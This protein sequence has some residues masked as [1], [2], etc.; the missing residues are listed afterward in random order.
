[1][2]SRSLSVRSR[3]SIGTSSPSTRA[4]A[5]DAT[6][7]CMSLPPS[8]ITRASSPSKSI[9]RHLAYRRP[10]WAPLPLNGGA[11]A[12]LTGQGARPAAR[13]NARARGGVPEWPKGTGCKPVGSA[14]RGSN[15]LSPMTI[16]LGRCRSAAASG[17]ALSRSGL[18][19]RGPA[20]LAAGG[21]LLSGGPALLRAGPGARRA[22]LLP[23]SARGTWRV[24]DLGGPLLGHALV[25]ERLVLLL[26][27]DVRLLV[28]HGP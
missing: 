5:G 3:S 19:G 21:L 15:P 22:G 11:A 17:R 25:L 27:P 18:A 8:S 16:R 28:R 6:L 26:V 23:A 14:F 2:V 10:A 9:R 13:Y 20:A 12:A 7:R 1:M 24:G 4:I